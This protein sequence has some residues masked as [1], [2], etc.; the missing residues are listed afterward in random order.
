MRDPTLHESIRELEDSKTQYSLTSARQGAVMVLVTLSGE[1]WEVGFFEDR[2]PE[3][4]IF[5]SDGNI[6][7]LESAPVADGN[8][9][10]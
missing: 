6:F 1:R 2:E 4:Q 7:A 9:D 3:V 10:V 5:R 8:E